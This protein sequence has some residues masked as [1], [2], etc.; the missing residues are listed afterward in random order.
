[1][2]GRGASDERGRPRPALVEALSEPRNEAARSRAGR[3]RRSR[4]A[5]ERPRRTLTA[6][7]S[8]IRA[9]DVG[10]RAAVSSSA[11]VHTLSGRSHCAES[12]P[13]A[14]TGEAAGTGVRS[15][16]PRAVVA[17]LQRRGEGLLARRRRVAAAREHLEAVAEPTPRSACGASAPIRPAASS[18]ASGRPSRRKQIRAMVRGVVL[19]ERESPAAAAAARSRPSRT[20]SNR[21]SSSEAAPL[22]VG[23]VDEAHGTRLAGHPQGLAAGVR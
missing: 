17:P 9:E 18:S 22:W 19:V 11:S 5:Y 21:P 3:S 15:S 23:D 6:T 12:N 13:P 4:F 14:N 16:P 2:R 20:A 10:R 1:M 7:S 8:T